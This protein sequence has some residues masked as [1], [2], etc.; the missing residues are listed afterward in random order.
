[1]IAFSSAASAVVCA[2]NAL[3]LAQNIIDQRILDSPTPPPWLLND[4]ASLSY[5]RSLSSSDIKACEVNG[6]P[7]HILSSPA[8]P[9]LTELATATTRLRAHFPLLPSPSLPARLPRVTPHK[10][11]QIHSIAST[12]KALL[13]LPPTTRV[14]DV[15]G[16]HG[17]L[18]TALSST[19]ALPASVVDKDGALITT[20]RALA[21]DRGP[22]V[23]FLHRDVFTG[24]YASRGD[25]VVALHACGALGDRVVSDAA[26]GASGDALCLVSC[27]PQK[28]FG[29]AARLPL[30]QAVN[31]L[32]RSMLSSAAPTSLGMANRARGRPLSEADLRGRVTRLGVQRILARRGV[33][34]SAK[35]AVAGV[36]RHRIKRG[37]GEVADEVLRRHG[38]CEVAV[39]EIEEVEREARKD[40]ERMRVLS[41]PRAM[42]GEILEVAIVLDRAALLEECGRFRVVKTCRIFDDLVSPRNLSI[43]AY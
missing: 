33:E 9:L 5:L 38:L 37:L 20:G 3:R 39:A 1:M 23:T 17:H 36:S 14:V 4:P 41:L 29:A 28:L 13:P 24:G 15:G 6:L 34:K 16:G 25:F 12:L 10:H 8:P 26:S 40:Y 18:A 31:D 35:D 27:C 11:A 7:S 32:P 21:A 43:I 2:A 30:S 19:L 42:V 22:D